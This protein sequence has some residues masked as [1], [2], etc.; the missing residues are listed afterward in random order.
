MTGPWTL[1]DVVMVSAAVYGAA[2]AMVWIIN[3]V[4]RIRVSID[5]GRR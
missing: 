2:E 3:R 4:S 5:D 1:I